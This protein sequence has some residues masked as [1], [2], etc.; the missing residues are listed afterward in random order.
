MNNPYQ[1][2]L[3]AITQV[4]LE[5]PIN[6]GTLLPALKNLKA[7][8]LKASGLDMSAKANNQDLF[9]DTGKAIGPVWAALCI[10]DLLR[11]KRFISGTCQAIRAALKTKKGEPVTL[12][13]VGTGPFATLVMPLTTIFTPEELQLILVEVNPLTLNSLKNCISSLGVAPY[14][15]EILSADASQLQLETPENIDILLLECMQA[16]LE[17]EQQVAITYNL[18]PQLKQE[19]I[20]VP[21]QIKLSIC[22]VDSKKKMDHMTGGNTE[23]PYFKNLQPIFILDKNEV[24]Q[25][26]TSQKTND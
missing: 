11:S 5:E 23:K 19:V 13:Y 26:V 20:L 15:K 9:H 14:V 12:L 10:D 21:E 18:L 24:L 1:Q 22:L 7:L 3:S 8:F 17:K 4:I 6:Y 25:S 2:E 16:A